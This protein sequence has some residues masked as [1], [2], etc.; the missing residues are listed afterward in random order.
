MSSLSSF[1]SWVADVN[2]MAG[3]NEN[4]VGIQNAPNL[5]PR[6]AQKLLDGGKLQKGS[7]LPVS[8]QIP[9]PLVVW[10]ADRLVEC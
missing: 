8:L 10:L 2:P 5:R 6:A 7:R 3:N 9:R 4:S 1:A